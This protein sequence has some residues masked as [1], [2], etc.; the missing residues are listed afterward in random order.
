MDIIL[1]NEYRKR[2]K[3]KIP[4]KYGGNSAMIN[5]TRSDLP[6]LEKFTQYLEKIWETRW[7]T[8]DGEFV[9]LLEK[10]LSDYLE[11][12]NLILLSNGTIAMQLALKA[13]D[14][15]G[16]VITTPF[17]FSATTNV[18][19]WE[20][21]SPVFV[22]IDSETFNLKPGDIERSITDKT[23]AILAVHVYGNPCYVEE[24]QNIASEYNLK[25]IYDAAHCFGVQYNGQSVLNYGD[26]STMSFHAT[27]L[28]HSIEGGA[29]ITE[30]D[31]LAEKLKLIRNFG[32]VSE[33]KV[34][35]PGVNAKMN[36]FQAAMGLCNLENIDERILKRQQIYE[37]YQE[38]LADI[39]GISFQKIIASRY[40]Y[41]YMPVCFENNQI[42][43]KIYSEL[44]NKHNIKTRKYFYPLT[45]DFDYF[46]DSKNNY[47]VN[48]NKLN[49]AHSV[50]DRILCLPLYT[51]LS[52]DTVDIIVGMIKEIVSK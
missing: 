22:D 10:K 19:L 47:K 7:L 32:I 17:T 28:Y 37:H 48:K 45:A 16:E 36:E 23:S 50:S 35:L 14:I 25:L 46:L 33:E 34:V 24:L 20:N 44:I 30:D 12:K 42:R 2:K 51:D 8:N 31:E 18:I 4:D 26:I 5:V 1:D 9:Q 27:K 49:I 43:N 41:I 52:T 6:P 13:L 11:V 3:E 15:K 29:A 39:P 38:K 40:N 21:C